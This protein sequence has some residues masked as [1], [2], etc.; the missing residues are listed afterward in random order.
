MS[1]NSKMLTRIEPFQTCIFP[2][3]IQA[4]LVS[5]SVSAGSDQCQYGVSLRLQRLVES[6]DREP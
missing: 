3:E 5:V 4:V 2:R 6:A 1:G